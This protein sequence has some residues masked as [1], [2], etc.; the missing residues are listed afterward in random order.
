MFSMG[1]FFVPI[2]LLGLLLYFW[3][4]K[5][6]ETRW[7][8]WLFVVT[9]FL[10]EMTITAGWWTAEIGRQPWI[11]YN[12]LQTAQGVSPD[13]VRYRGGHLVA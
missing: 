1:T 3:K 10:A 11:V 2:G 8:L 7:L 5:V 13:A 9:V 12:V 4:R 6:F